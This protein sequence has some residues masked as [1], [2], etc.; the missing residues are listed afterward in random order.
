[1]NKWVSGSCAFSWDSSIFLLACFVQLWHGG[2]CFYH[3]IYYFVLFGYLLEVCS[4]LMRDRKRVDSGGSGW[5]GA[6]WSGGGKDFIQII[7][8]EG[9]S[10]FNKKRKKLKEKQR[11]RRTGCM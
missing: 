6:R 7:L 8:Y 4:V 9:E 1:V 10:M 3:T 11:L 2:V 5:G